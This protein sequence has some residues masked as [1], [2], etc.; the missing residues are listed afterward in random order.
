MRKT[1]RAKFKGGLIEPLEP[2]DL[3]EGRELTVTVEEEA[4]PPKGRLGASFGLVGD[5]LMDWDAFL[6][7]IY[8]QRKRRTRPDVTFDD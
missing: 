3:P 4:P 8:S 6:E 5:D 7:E 1:I 2:V